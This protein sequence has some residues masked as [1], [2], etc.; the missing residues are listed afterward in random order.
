[1]ARV[2]QELVEACEKAAKT[3]EIFAAVH[4]IE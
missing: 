4:A 1:V 3:A 2:R